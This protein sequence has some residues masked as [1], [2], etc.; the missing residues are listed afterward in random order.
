MTMNIV[1]SVRG[2]G[3]MSA[4][5]GWKSGVGAVG[6]S[7]FSLGEAG[8]VSGGFGVT[9]GIFRF[10]LWAGTSSLL[11]EGVAAVRRLVDRGI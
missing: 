7:R 8:S 11:K 10:L 9:L 1:L 6:E 4:I 3:L 5:E 2:V